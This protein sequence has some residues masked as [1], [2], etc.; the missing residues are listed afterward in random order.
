MR[1]LIFFLVFLLSFYTLPAQS[2][3][4]FQQRRI[5]MLD[6][7]EDQ[8]LANYENSEVFF[9]QVDKLQEILFKQALSSDVRKQIQLG[10]YFSLVNFRKTSSLNSSKALS[11]TFLERYLFELGLNKSASFFKANPIN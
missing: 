8:K 1:C 7:I 11:Y 2:Y 10:I 6:G 9:E 5:D 3:I 4:D